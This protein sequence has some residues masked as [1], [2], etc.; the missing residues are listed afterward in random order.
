[1]ARFD[2]RR[3][4]IARTSRGF[5]LVEL[6][7]VIAIIAILIALLLPAIQHVRE[8]ARRSHCT[9]NLK[10]IALALHAHHDAK[11]RFPPGNVTKGPCCNTKSYTNWAIEILPYLEL[12]SLYKQ[13]RQDK[14]NEDPENAAVRES[15]V[16]VYQC[17]SEIGVDTLDKPDSGPGGTWNN[18]P[19]IF[20]RRGSYRAMTGRSDGTFWWDTD[21]NKGVSRK[22]RGV[23][24][25]VGTN[26]LQ[27]ESIKNV[28]D[29][30]SNTL[31]IGET[32]TYTRQQRRTFWAYSYGPYIH[33]AAVPQPRT[34]WVDYDRCTAAGGT[35]KDNPCKRGWGSFHPNGLQ[36]AFCDGSVNFLSTEIDMET[37]CRL[38]TIAEGLHPEKWPPE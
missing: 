8:A 31:M 30:M 18:Q 38:A 25:T 16:P 36:F 22:L 1:M 5:T 24:H 11:N 9:N 3:D 2:G 37:F 21:E 12:M 13:Y 33:S 29:G 7:V 32:S 23:L 10:Q 20:Y 17:P 27:P 6:L 15:S 28:T 4:V 19:G 14:F 26:G 35:G 34:L